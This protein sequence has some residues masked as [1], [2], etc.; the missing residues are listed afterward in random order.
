VAG[1]QMMFQAMQGIA[2]MLATLVL[3]G[4]AN[5]PIIPI[6]LPLAYFFIK[7]RLPANL[8]EP[9]RTTCVHLASP[10]VLYLKYQNAVICSF[11][12]AERQK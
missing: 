8:Q 7:V 6:V 5:P 9:S 10:P 2:I 1:V 3:V 12:Q 11:L 4:I